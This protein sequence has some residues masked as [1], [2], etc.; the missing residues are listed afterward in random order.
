MI[1]DFQTIQGASPVVDLL[2]FIFTS[3]DED[4]RQEYYDKLIN[5]Y[6]TELS[7]ALKR[8]NLDPEKIYSRDDYDR[9]LKEVTSIMY[10]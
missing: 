4:F 7:A 2:Y 10:L 6:Y 9:E 3:S 8:L 5:H 1:V